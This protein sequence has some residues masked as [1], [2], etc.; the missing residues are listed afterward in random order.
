MATLHT[1]LDGLQELL[2]F[3]VQKNELQVV[4]RRQCVMYDLLSM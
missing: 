2:V 3:D 4:S 1:L